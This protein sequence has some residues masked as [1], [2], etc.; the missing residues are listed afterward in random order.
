VERLRLCRHQLHTSVYR[1]R[2]LCQMQWLLQE[3]L[4]LLPLGV[5][6]LPLLLVALLLRPRP[7]PP[8]W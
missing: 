2:L 7:V 3:H 4:V 8:R 5:G 1:F 6:L